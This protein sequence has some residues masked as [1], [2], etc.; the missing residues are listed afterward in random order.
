MTHATDGLLQAYLDGEID[1]TAEAELRG[2]LAACGACAQELN[3]LESASARA[4]DAL[5]VLDVTAPMMR[6]RARLAAER[7][8]A[9]PLVGRR[10]SLPRMGGR[11][12][13]KAAMLLLALAGAGAA[14]IPESPVRRALESTIARVAQLFGPGAQAPVAEV[15]VTAP[16]PVE[17]LTPGGMGVLPAD[18]RVRVVLQAPAG[19][20]SVVVRLVESQRATVQTATDGAGVR[21]RTAPGRVEVGGLTSGEVTISIP[22][23][24]RDATVEIGGAVWAYKQGNVLQLTG[25]AG[26][27][28]GEQVSF[29][30]G[31]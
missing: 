19:E 5:S 29:R 20:V 22:R 30:L 2:H 21:F 13:A 3:V 7:R 26:V 31:T 12:L 4:H 16:A 23:G 10:R 9:D 1:G 11:S 14:A 18:G 17:P 27:E 24:T 6:A 28:R 25:P 8:T 15:P